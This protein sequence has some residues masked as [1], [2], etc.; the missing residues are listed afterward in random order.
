MSSAQQDFEG[1]AREVIQDSFHMDPVGATWMG[2]HTFDSL[3]PDLTKYGQ[4]Q[5][6]QRIEGY[7][8]ALDAVDDVELALT[9]L[10]DLE[11]LRAFLTRAHFDIT[12]VAA[13]TWNPMLWNP[14]T[15]IHLLLS[16][17][18][19]PLEERMANVADRCENIPDF[20]EQARNTLEEMPAI[21]CET[22][23]AQ[24]AGTR[25]LLE[26]LDIQ[27]QIIQSLD[28]HVEWLKEQLPF[29]HKSPRMG[30]EIYSGILWHSLDAESSAQELLVAAH[31]HLDLVNSQMLHVAQEYLAEIDI[32]IEENGDPISCALAQIAESAPVTDSTVL[33]QVASAMAAAKAF[34]IERDLV[35]VPEIDVEV[36]QMPEIHRGVAVAYCDAPGPLE[37]AHVPTFVAVAPT[38]A[39]WASER[40]ESFFR[41]Y[42]GVQIHD[43]TIHEAIPGH[44]LQLA[45]A[46]H[47]SEQSL[48]RRFG[49]SGTFVEGWAVYA[50]ELLISQGYSPEPTKP[51]ALA[52]RLQQLKMQARMSIN[53]ILDVSVH[54]QEIDEDEAMSLMINRGYQEESEA[55]GK[56]RRALLTAGQLPTYFVGYRE[57]RQLAEDLRLMHPDWSWREVHDLMLQF[58]SP[59]PRHVRQLLGL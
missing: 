34:T 49:F 2:E 13:H 31:Q 57:V 28:Q 39:Q 27:P 23:I 14:G 53:A 47:G 48:T 10:V 16:R 37:Q 43:L 46:S 33:S 38:P 42:N 11:I 40:K 8:T 1:I 21:H 51:S 5:F 20:L 32:E 55:A 35:T 17:D 50:E 41:E 3:L 18:F 6:A 29:A 30:S 52:I 7:L 36:I 59:A 25:A 54:T 19:A 24:L 44:V 56:W 4:G 15:A 22:A 26:S 12:Q 45:V 58:G 9:D